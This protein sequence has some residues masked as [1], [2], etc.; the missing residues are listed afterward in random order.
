MVAA[1][2][3]A[4]TFSTQS[5]VATD[6]VWI[7]PHAYDQTGDPI[8]RAW[9]DGAK[10]V[11]DPSDSTFSYSI[12]RFDL[13]GVKEDASKLSKATLV[14]YHV[15]EAVFTAAETKSAPLEARLVDANFD[16][17]RWTF[18]QYSKHLPAAG[19]ASLLGKASPVPTTDGKPFKIEIDLL[20]GKGNLK[21]AIA[22]K[23]A[24][25][26]ALSTKMAP[27][28]TDGPYYRLLSRTN[29][30]GVQPTLVLEFAD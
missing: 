5:L 26:I 19:E 14:V 30:K 1:I 2:L 13:S 4:A 25:A 7:Y 27:E 16:E 20:T 11:G 21:A 22:E 12:V 8:L 18:E 17:K 15:P 9:S 23:K 3:F 10:S 24:V 29:E 28:G 6:D